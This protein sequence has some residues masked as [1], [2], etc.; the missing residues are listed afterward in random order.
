VTALPTD[1]PKSRAWRF[2]LARLGEASTL[3]GF[4]MILTAG[5]IALKPEV[6]D[7]IVAVG[8]ALAGLVGV[9]LPDQTAE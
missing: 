1:K 5:G 8:I 7:A 9:I 6:S 4:L 2:I 3:R